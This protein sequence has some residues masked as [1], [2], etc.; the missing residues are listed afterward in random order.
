VEDQLVVDNHTQSLA[1]F[2]EFLR[3]LTHSEREYLQRVLLATKSSLREDY[4]QANAWQLGSR[5]KAKLR[6]YFYEETG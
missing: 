4:S 3:T 5:I 1:R 6:T 2:D